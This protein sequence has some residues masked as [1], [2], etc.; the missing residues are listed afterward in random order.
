MEFDIVF[1]HKRHSRVS[2]KELLQYTEMADIAT[3]LSIC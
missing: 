2:G 3:D 1:Q